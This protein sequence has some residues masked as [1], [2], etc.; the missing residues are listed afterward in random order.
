M[1][2]AIV[3]RNKLT[4][5]AGVKYLLYSDIYQ[6]QYDRSAWLTGPAFKILIQL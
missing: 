3:G 4:T 1:T 2:L 5:E 6:V